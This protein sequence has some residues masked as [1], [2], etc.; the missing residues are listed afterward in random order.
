MKVSVIV[1]SYN[2]NVDK[3]KYT[4][5]SIVTQ[6]MDDYEVIVCDDGSKCNNQEFLMEYFSDKSVNY[7]LVLNEENKGTVENIL[8]GI[9]VS[10]GEYIKPIGTGD[11]F[12]EAE[13]LEK[14]YGFMKE[15]EA[16]IAYVDMNFISAGED[17]TDF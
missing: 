13:A 4:L 14:V 5:D 1:C 16:V 8:S 10:E 12:S 9:K 11:R 17:Q 3:L 15:K 2:S 7:K 6:T